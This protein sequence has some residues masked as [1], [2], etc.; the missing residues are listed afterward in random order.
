MTTNQTTEDFVLLTLQDRLRKYGVITEMVRVPRTEKTS[1][2]HLQ[3]VGTPSIWITLGR[4]NGIVPKP[5]VKVGRS[6]STTRR[7]PVSENGLCN[8]PKIAK[9]ISQL[10]AKSAVVAQERMKAEVRHEIFKRSLRKWNADD[11]PIYGTMAHLKN[12]AGDTITVYQE[13]DGLRV[14]VVRSVKMDFN[15]MVKFLDEENAM[16]I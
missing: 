7:Y 13:D 3:P 12:P 11:K 15:A 14:E 8:A 10:I 9:Y 4:T 6:I 5:I 16:V 1:R 2:A